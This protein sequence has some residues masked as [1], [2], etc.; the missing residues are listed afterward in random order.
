M[1]VVSAG[2]W[3]SGVARQENIVSHA[4]R[5]DPSSSPSHPRCRAITAS[6]MTVARSLNPNVLGVSMSTR[7]TV[8]VQGR[9]S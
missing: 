4:E 1:D 9:P 7:H 5:A 2:M 8:T 3:W 6:E